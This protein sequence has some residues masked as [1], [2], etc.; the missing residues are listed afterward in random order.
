MK[1]QL[2][3]IILLLSYLKH[4]IIKHYIMGLK[5]QLEN[6]E[7]ATT[8]EELTD[9]FKELAPLFLYGGYFNVGDRYLVYI[10]TIE[11]YF[12]AENG[13]LLSIKDP[14]VYHRNDKYVEGEVPY[15][16]VMALN[17]HV[18]GIDITFENEEMK[19]RASA[20]IRAYEV[21]DVKTKNYLTCKNG[22]FLQSNDG[23]DKII[24]QSTYIY[25]FI[26]GFCENNINWVD[27]IITTNDII[28]KGRQN[29]FKSKFEEE[30]VPELDSCEKKIKD[31]RLWSFSRK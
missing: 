24:T 21:F 29:V 20:L 31:E 13:S 16:P 30:Y 4:N 23:K 9:K 27:Q 15:F 8:T 28:Q 17:A 12:H 26:N 10:N 14:I 25:N 22:K 19:Y 3:S 7:G 11:F 18:S 6:F 1:Y 2:W 5:E